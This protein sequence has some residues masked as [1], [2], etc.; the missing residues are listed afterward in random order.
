MKKMK[1]AVDTIITTAKFDNIGDAE[2]Y[3]NFLKECGYKYIEMK[4]IV[5]DFPNNYYAKSIK[6]YSK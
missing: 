3:F 6:I 2:I 4:E 1:Y 5:S